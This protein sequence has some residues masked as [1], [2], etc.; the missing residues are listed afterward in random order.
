MSAAFFFIGL[1]CY[2]SA[3]REDLKLRMQ[4]IHLNVNKKAVDPEFKRNLFT[5]IQFHSQLFE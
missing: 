4:A 1:C 5:D 3:M 2:I